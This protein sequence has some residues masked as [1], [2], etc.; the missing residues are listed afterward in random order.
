MTTLRYKLLGRSGLRVSELCL[1]TMTFGDDWGWGAPPDEARR[2]YEVFR[3]AGGN[4]VDTANNYTNGSSEKIVGE[5]IREERA[6]IVLATKYTIAWRKGDPNAA[7]NHRKNMVQ[8]VEASLT[9]LGTDYLDLLWL[10]AWDDS[11]PPSEVMRA[12]DDL[13]RAGKVLHVGVSDTPA[14][15]VSHANTLAELRGWSPFVALQ[16][17]HS[18]IQRTVERDLTPM[19][20][21]FGLAECAWGAIGGGVLTGKYTRGGDVDAKR[22]TSARRS[23]RNL[24]IARAVDAVADALGTTSTRVAVAWLLHQAG[25]VIPIIGARTAAQLSDSLGA[26]SVALHDAHLQELHTASAIELGFPHEFLRMDYVRKLV[27]G[28]TLDRQVFDARRPR[29]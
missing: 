3:A 29:I 6:S 19:A 25:T 26:A 21:A 28:D 10:H 16:I 20:R 27:A 1:G 23:E 7:G 4:F 2:Q 13:V 18:L 14:W 12:L 22:D 24:T 15:V 5:L 11:T 9:R 17:E 8:S